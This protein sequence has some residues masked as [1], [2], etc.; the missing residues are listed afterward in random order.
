MKKQKERDM[1]KK[2]WFYLLPLVILAVIACVCLVCGGGPGLGEEF[3]LSVGQTVGISGEN[4]KITFDEVSQDSR[5]PT[6]V[7]CA[8]EGVVICQVSIIVDSTTYRI[9]LAQTG[10]SDEYVSEVYKN[11]RFTFKVK[12]YPEPDKE[13]ATSEYQLLLTI[14]K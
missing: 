9:E 4:L 10:L 13:I 8:W 3:S 7:E 6:D 1:K 12:P 5:C 11:Y 2:Y 14:D